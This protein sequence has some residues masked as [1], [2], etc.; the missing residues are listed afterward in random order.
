MC[1]MCSKHIAM[2]ICIGTKRKLIRHRTTGICIESWIR[3][4]FP[5]VYTS[6]WMPAFK[7]ITGTSN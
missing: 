7:T 1:L 6:P 4:L 2:S 5:N 3:S